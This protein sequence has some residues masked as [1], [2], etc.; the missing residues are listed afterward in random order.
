MKIEEIR[1]CVGILE[2]QDIEAIHHIA[3]IKCNAALVCI[4]CPLNIPD[5]CCLKNLARDIEKGLK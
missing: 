3:N 2:I 4:N 1:K 5:N